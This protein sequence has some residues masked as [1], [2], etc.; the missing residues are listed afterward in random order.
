MKKT[1]ILSFTALTV[2][3]ALS[4]AQQSLPDAP[5]QRSISSTYY[6]PPTESERFKSYVKHTYSFSSLLEAG[7][8]GGI[9]QAVDRPSGWPQGAEGYGDRFGSAAGQI[10]IR[11]TM[12]YLLADAFHE[13][14]RTTP[15][16]SGCAESKLKAAFD[17]T[18][19]ARKGRDGHEAL[20]VARLVAPWSGSAVAVS[21]W[22]PSGYGGGEIARQASLSYAFNFIRN[23]IREV[24]AH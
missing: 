4:F 14:L 9:D 13:D 20:S 11:K 12:E 24:H 16:G 2:C 8:R 23:Y 3:P 6:Q 5:S 15:C 7:V 22:Y 21:T 18:F 1:L 17:D 19:L 10:V